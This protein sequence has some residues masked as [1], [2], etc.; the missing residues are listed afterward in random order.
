MKCPDCQNELQVIKLKGIDIHECLKC[1]SKW[2]ER[3]E[4]MSVKNKADDGLMWLD[5]D[6]F[7][8]DVEKLSVPSD[9]KHCPRCLKKMQSLTY[10]YSKIV[11][12]K[13]QTC[14]GVWLTHGELEKIIR[15]LEKV[16]NTQP[17]KDLAKDTFRE[18]TKIF[19]GHKGLVTEVKDFLAVLKILKVRIAV[20]HPRL[21]QT[22][23]DIEG[24]VPFR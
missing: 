23:D 14:E 21:A 9:G 22:W 11:I 7:G 6:P 5:F 4:L 17:V 15:F 1:K 2:F 18:F 20:E 13:C 12:D 10:F 3:N 19:I 16:I 24:Y 8:K